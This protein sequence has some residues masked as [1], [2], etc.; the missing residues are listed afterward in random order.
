MIG[1]VIVLSIESACA[2]HGHSTSAASGPVGQDKPNKTAAEGTLPQAAGQP[3][4]QR[5][6]S[7]DDAMDLVKRLRHQIEGC[8]TLPARLDPHKNWPLVVIDIHL[9]RNGKVEGR[10][11]LAHRARMSDPDFRA[12]AQSAVQA[13]EACQPYDLP[14]DQ[15]DLWKNVR[16]N[17]DPHDVSRS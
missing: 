6:A 9:R 1:C 12:A 8:W 7:A 17:F 13:I 16:L 10:P 15:Y 4:Q 3:S 11:A 2:A 14:A 5:H